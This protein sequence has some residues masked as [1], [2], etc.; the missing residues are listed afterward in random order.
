M[1]MEHGPIPGNCNDTFAEV[2][3]SPLSHTGKID[4]HASG[5]VDVKNRIDFA[6]KA[7]AAFVKASTCRSVLSDISN[8]PSLLIEETDL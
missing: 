1:L 6:T 5:S 8:L 7:E 3:A 4:F 2:A